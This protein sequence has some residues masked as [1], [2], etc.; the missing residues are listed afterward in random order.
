MTPQQAATAAKTTK[1]KVVVKAA[2]VT[3]RKA[4]AGGTSKPAA[5]AQRVS[6]TET[7]TATAR[8]AASGGRETEASSAHPHP[9]VAYRLHALLH[10]MHSIEHREDQLCTLL[11]EIERAGVLAPAVRRE[12]T[13][14]LE[15]LPSQAFL[16]DLEAARQALAA[17]A[18]PTRKRA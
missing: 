15:E 1:S 11:T 18:A 3:K 16:A 6:K 5:G 9:P 10:T 8:K 17:A 13:M 14:L 7:R 2:D 4:V 12:L